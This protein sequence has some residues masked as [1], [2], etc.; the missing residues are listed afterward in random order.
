MESACKWKV[1]K[2]VLGFFS[3]KEI[4]PVNFEKKDLTS[5]S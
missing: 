5:L 1:M 4:N 3:L 2:N